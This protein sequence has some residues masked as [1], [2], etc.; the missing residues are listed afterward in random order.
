MQTRLKYKIDAQTVFGGVT[1][2]VKTEEEV[3]KLKDD[4]SPDG[5]EKADED[6]D[7]A[8][9]SDLLDRINMAIL[10]AGPTSEVP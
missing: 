6:K 2:T 1:V 5:W 10:S 3:E 7:T 9:A 8:R 4:G